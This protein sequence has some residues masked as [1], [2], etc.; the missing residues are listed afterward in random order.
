MKKFLFL[1]ALFS[2]TFI[3]MSFNLKAHAD[4]IEIYDH[5]KTFETSSGD[6]L[7]LDRTRNTSY[8]KY[9]ANLNDSKALDIDLR[10]YNWGNLLFTE[11]SRYYLFY[12]SMQ[13]SPDDFRSQVPFIV[14]LEKDLSKY[15]VY[16]NDD[17]VNFGYITSLIEYPINEFIAIENI[18]G[19]YY[20][21]TYS[22]KYELFSFDDD[23]NVKSSIYVTSKECRVNIAI[24]TIEVETDDNDKYYFDD[25]FNLISDFSLEKNVVGSFTIYKD[26]YVNEKYT[27][28][29]TSFNTPGKYT[30]RDDSHTYTVNLKEKL[31]GIQNGHKYHE[32]VEYR[33]TGG[34]ITLNGS[35]VY[36]NG[37]V[38]EVGEYTLKVSGLNG[39]ESIYKFEIEPKLITEV[40]D[41]GSLLIGDL[42]KFTGYARINDGDYIKDSYE[43]KQSGTYKL[44]LYKDKTSEPLETIYFSVPELTV[45]KR[46]MTWAYIILGVAIAGA[47]LATVLLATSYKRK[48]NIS[49]NETK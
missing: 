21:G 43:I 10:G 40:E 47:T 36:L 45:S 41:G 11:S 22:G 7:S 46:D 29:G 6:N 12:G 13:K 4:D 5:L 48:K 23:L 42:L 17:V 19:D 3:S 18:S 33:S 16:F 20:F 34:T 26:S 31:I 14:R 27:T 49:N 2:L 39:Y 8:Y 30:I 32:F 37:I 9:R 38:S 35:V 44:S 24:D 1:F 15:K 28:A 25:E